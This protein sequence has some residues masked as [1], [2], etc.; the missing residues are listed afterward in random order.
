M[1][2]LSF[3]CGS[4]GFDVDF[5]RWQTAPVAD[6]ARRHGLNANLVFN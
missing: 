3:D 2:I 6:I 4:G 5:R 1:D